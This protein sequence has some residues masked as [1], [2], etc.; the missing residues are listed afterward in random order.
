MDAAKP[1]QCP[2]LPLQIVNP[3][4]PQTHCERSLA[5]SSAVRHKD[6]DAHDTRAANYTTVSSGPTHD[7]RFFYS[8]TYSTTH[9]EYSNAKLQN[10]I[11]GIHA[12]DLH[13]AKLKQR[14]GYSKNLAAFVNY[15]KSVDENADFNIQD[16]Y[17]TRTCS[18]YSRPPLLKDYLASPKA[19]ITGIVDSGFTRRPLFNV[20]QDGSS[21]F[22]KD[23]ETLMKACFTDGKLKFKET[24]VNKRFILPSATAYISDEGE[25]KSIGNP[26]V[27]T[28]A[29]RFAPDPRRPPKPS[30]KPWE[31]PNPDM[32]R[33]DGYTRSTRAKDPLQTD[34]EGMPEIQPRLLQGKVLE[35]VKH[36]DLAEWVH[37]NDPKADYSFSKVVHPPMDLMAS[38]KSIKEHPTRIGLKEPTGGVQNNDKFIF[39][40]EPNP[41][42]RFLTE[43]TT[44]FQYPALKSPNDPKCNTLVKSGFSDGNRYKYVN[45]A[46]TD[47][48]IFSRMHPTVAKYNWLNE[49][50]LHTAIPNKTHL[51]YK[52]VVE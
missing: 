20:T 8:T 47:E 35:K 2:D 16:P 27:V 34:Y 19:G 3:P 12:K 4:P 50:G 1:Q 28:E 52:L 42:E 45:K 32:I 39:L 44:R 30:S 43:T 24:H 31:C 22:N 51:G 18:D 9:K 25:I 6:K 14:T 13:N 40:P 5:P 29:D 11:N 33:P 10:P 36:S 26:D 48:Q 17:L 41:A 23:K 37:R 15:N 49:R 21:K 7:P 38:I 46:P